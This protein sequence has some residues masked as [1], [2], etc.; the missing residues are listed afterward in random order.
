MLP[1][2]KV[3]FIVSASELREGFFRPFKK[4]RIAHFRMEERTRNT[5][6]LLRLPEHAVIDEI[7]R[8]KPDTSSEGALGDAELLSGRQ[9]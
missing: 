8:L 4:N 9:V 3:S 7:E 2:C 1:R 6:I 5:D